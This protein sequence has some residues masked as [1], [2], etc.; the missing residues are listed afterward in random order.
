MSRAIGLY[1]LLLGLIFKE[2]L[3]KKL[4]KFDLN[5]CLLLRETLCESLCEPKELCW[6][7]SQ[8]SSLIPN[9]EF[10]VINYRNYMEFTLVELWIC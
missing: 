9:R 4:L 6:T 5:F 1:K 10:S 8:V 2:F 7:P 3:L